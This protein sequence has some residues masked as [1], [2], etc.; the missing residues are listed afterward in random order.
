MSVRIQSFPKDLKNALKV[1]EARKEAIEK[2]SPVPD[3][4]QAA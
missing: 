3:P 2:A 1:L 4:F